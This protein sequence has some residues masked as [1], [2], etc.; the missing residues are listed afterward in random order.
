MGQEVRM[1]NCGRPRKRCSFP[2]QC[3]VAVADVGGSCNLGITV[4][5]RGAAL[6]GKWLCNRKLTPAAAIKVVVAGSSL[7]GVAMLRDECCPKRVTART[8]ITGGSA[9]GNEFS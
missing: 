3:A 2:C 6:S 8:R 7:S 5:T 9:P 4:S 1:M